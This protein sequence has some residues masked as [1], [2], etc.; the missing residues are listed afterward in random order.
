MANKFVLL[1]KVVL[2]YMVVRQGI[3]IFNYKFNR[4]NYLTESIKI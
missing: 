4:T 2:A 1:V 3:Y